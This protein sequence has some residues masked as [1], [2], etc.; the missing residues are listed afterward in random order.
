[1][2][3]HHL[4]TLKKKMFIMTVMNLRKSEWTNSEIAREHIQM[5]WLIVGY[6]F[7]L[8]D[9]LRYS[10]LIVGEKARIFSHFLE[11]EHM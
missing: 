11:H 2:F 6:Q 4:L 5:F 10:L 8:V 9:P 3:V 7:N 1:V